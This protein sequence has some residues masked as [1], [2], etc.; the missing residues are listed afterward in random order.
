MMLI[1]FLLQSSLFVVLQDSDLSNCM[2][3]F[4]AIAQSFGR[5]FFSATRPSGIG[6][7]IHIFAVMLWDG[8]NILNLVKEF[9]PQ[10]SFSW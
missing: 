1:V 4:F 3:T 8:S 5:D 10:S 9:S 2:V 6:N 7:S